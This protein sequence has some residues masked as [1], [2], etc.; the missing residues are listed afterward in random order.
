[1]SKRAHAAA[2]A[3]ALAKFDREK[4][5]SQVAPLREALWAAEPRIRGED[6]LR[7]EAMSGDALGSVDNLTGWRLS[8]DGGAPAIYEDEEELAREVARRMDAGN[9]SI[10]FLTSSTP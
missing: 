5:G 4:F 8:G 3:S 6:C 10:R 1:M 2:K 7:I 9:L